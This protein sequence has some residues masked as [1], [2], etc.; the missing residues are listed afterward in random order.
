MPGGAPG[1]ES[2][3]EET[4]AAAA[5]ME[6]VAPIWNPPSPLVFLSTLASPDR[7]CSLEPAAMVRGPGEE[8]GV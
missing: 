8:A 4:A 7:L 1:N 3:A 5:G 6:L 2:D